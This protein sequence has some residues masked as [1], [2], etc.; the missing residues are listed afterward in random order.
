MAG[1]TEQGFEKKTLDELRLELEASYRESF[2]VFINLIPGS[3]FATLIG[4]QADRLSS[5]WDL[6]EE[7]YLSRY[8]NTAK[9]TSLD[10]VGAFT[11]TPRIGGARSLVFGQLFFGDVGSEIT[12]DSMRVSVQG[13]PSAIF[14]PTQ[15]ITLV[16]GVNEEQKVAFAD[17]PDAG[18]FTLDYKGTLTAAIDFDA[19][20]EEI[21]DIIN[22]I[23]GLNVEVAGDFSSGFTIEF[24]GGSGV[25][26]QSL[27]VANSL[28]TESG[29]PVAITVT[30]E[31]IGEPQGQVNMEAVDIGARQA[32][33][34]TLTVIDTPTS[35]VISTF[36]PDDAAIGRLPE[37]DAEY[38]L[39]RRETLSVQGRASVDAIR[40]RLLTL[41]D[42]QSV[43]VYEN[44]TAAT[45]IA[46]RPPK[47]F[48]AVIE[49]AESA[50]IAQTIWDSK[51]AGIQA[52][53]NDS[54]VAFDANGLERTINFS[55]PVNVPIYL[56]LDIT[57]NSQF[58]A[59]GTAIMLERILLFSEALSISENIVIYP[60]FVS[61]FNGI[62]GLKNIR[63]RI[64][65][66]PVSDTPGDPA[67][68]DNI[69][70]GEIE[71]AQFSSTNTTI[72]VL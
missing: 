40:A 69:E 62:P 60:T 64:D 45:D 44:D 58:P 65:T 33:M 2:G 31:V 51:S 18:T 70:L 19:T 49:G 41:P 17:V 4:I 10:N 66:D 72:N 35:G 14:R 54:D 68:T 29:S 28:L 47:S 71:R 24:V 3:V 36:N 21:E 48:E 37:T 30:K 12:V 9:G 32:P 23:P 8:A 59:N 57:T 56:S 61:I 34:G 39:R 42:V 13:N 20:D 5:V 1:L 6:L 67:L 38:R 43:E 63:I 46:G 27:F 26:P 7:V 55:R 22:A 16:A 25:Q 15:N 11:N 50:L 53:G 52:H